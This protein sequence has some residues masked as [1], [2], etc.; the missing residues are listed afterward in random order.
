MDAKLVILPDE[1]VSSMLLQ[2]YEDILLGVL[3]TQYYQ[4]DSACALC[5]LCH[6]AAATV[7]PATE[8][9]CAPT[10]SVTEDTTGPKTESLET[11]NQESGQG[12]GISSITA[13]FGL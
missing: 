1:N 8:E 4:P 12:T 6:T 3:V 13:S 11:D 2:Q 10:A 5:P 9:R 7:Q